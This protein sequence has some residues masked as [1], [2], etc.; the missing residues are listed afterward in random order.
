MS[1]AAPDRGE[2][3]GPAAS[4]RLRLRRPGRR[5]TERRGGPGRVLARRLVGRR[6][7]LALG[8]EPAGPAA[9]APRAGAGGRRQRRRAHPRRLPADLRPRGRL[10]RRRQRAVHRR[11]RARA[12]PSPAAT[13]SPTSRWSGPRTA[14]S[15]PAELGDAEHLRVGQLVV[16]IGN[17][18]GFEGS[19]TAGVVSALG[20]ALPADRRPRRAGD[21]QRDPDRR[22]AQPGQLGR[23]A[24]RRAR[25]AD[26]R[27][28]RGRRG[29]ARARGAGERHDPADHRGADRRRPRAPRLSRDRRRT[30]A[31]AAAR[32]RRGRR[33]ARGGGGRDRPGQPRRRRRPAGR[34]RDL[35]ARRRPRSNRPPT[36]SG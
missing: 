30:G 10:E 16:A 33:R 4:S 19:V 29:R 8:R 20:R 24:R 36:S 11:S 18:H 17:P 13:R 35:R 23:R 2:G 22:G 6:A 31:A 14:S 3:A 7:A 15:T 9:H 12:S 28:H 32:S 1:F 21:R 34:R 26:R 27:Q 5:S 25:Q